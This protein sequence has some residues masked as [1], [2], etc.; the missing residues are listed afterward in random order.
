MEKVRVTKI[1][2]NTAISAFI[3]EIPSIEMLKVCSQHYTLTMSIEVYHEALT[4][5]RKLKQT[6]RMNV[7]SIKKSRKSGSMTQSI[8]FF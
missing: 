2:D 6:A 7:C 8:L 3:N 5:F 4:G 1:F